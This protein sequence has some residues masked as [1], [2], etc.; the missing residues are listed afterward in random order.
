MFEDFLCV[1]IHV[2]RLG[3]VLYILQQKLVVIRED[4]NYGRDKSHKG[5]ES[6]AQVHIDADD[7]QI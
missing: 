5:R 6:E 1:F 3:I 4:D 2:V 7:S